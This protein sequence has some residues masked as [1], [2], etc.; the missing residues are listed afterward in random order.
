VEGNNSVLSWITAN[1]FHF[2]FLTFVSVAQLSMI[3]WRESN[4]FSDNWK[5]SLHFP[6]ER[7]DIIHYPV[8]IFEKKDP[9]VNPIEM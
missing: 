2:P 3:F 6:G 7:C 9:F 5:L 4:S 8:N 1:L